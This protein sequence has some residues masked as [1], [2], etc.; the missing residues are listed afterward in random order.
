MPALAQA[1]MLQK[2]VQQMIARVLNC[3]TFKAG[4]EET[5]LEPVEITGAKTGDVN[6]QIPGTWDTEGSIIMTGSDPLDVTVLA[7]AVIVDAGG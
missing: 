5:L 2:S 1:Q 7:V 3:Y 6:I 4:V